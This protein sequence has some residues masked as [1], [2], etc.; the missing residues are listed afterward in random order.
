MKGKMNPRTYTFYSKKKKDL[1][2][3]AKSSQEWKKRNW[4]QINVKLIAFIYGITLYTRVMHTEFTLI[5]SIIFSRKLA[6]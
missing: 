1:Y 2:F 4:S 5:S 6:I 3:H